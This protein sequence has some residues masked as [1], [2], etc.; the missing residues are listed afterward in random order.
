[1]RKEVYNKMMKFNKRDSRKMFKEVARIHG[2]SVSEVKK[3]MQVAID[4]A[5]N[6]PDPEKQAEFQRLFGNRTPTPEEFI[7]VTSKKLFK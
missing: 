3:Q 2:I 4:E 6:N 7:C 1:M 5:R